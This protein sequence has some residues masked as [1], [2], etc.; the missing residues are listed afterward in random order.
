MVVQCGEQCVLVWFIRQVVE[1]VLVD[2]IV[3]VCVVDLG[4]Q[5]GVEDLC[6]VEVVVIILVV[7]VVSLVFEVVV[8]QVEFVVKGQGVGDGLVFD[9]FCCL[10]VVGGFQYLGFVGVGD[11]EVVVVVDVFVVVVGWVVL[12]VML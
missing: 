3:L 4:Q 6:E 1:E 9:F 5:V 7:L 10:Q 8:V 11:E 2:L 12:V